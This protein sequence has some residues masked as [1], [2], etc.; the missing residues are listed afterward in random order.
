MELNW[1]NMGGDW[2]GGPQLTELD[3][4]QLQATQTDQ[5]SLK[6]TKMEKGGF[7]LDFWQLLQ[8]IQV[9]LI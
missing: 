3:Q 6:K 5:D 1:N 8:I 2:Q 9:Q 4:H 7:V